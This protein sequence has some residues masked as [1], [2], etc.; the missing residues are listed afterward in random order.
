MSKK[1]HLW[2]F[3]V[4]NY[5]NENIFRSYNLEKKIFFDVTSS[6]H[7]ELVVYPC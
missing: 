7:L 5:N 4:I 2:V 1:A 3:F 6:F